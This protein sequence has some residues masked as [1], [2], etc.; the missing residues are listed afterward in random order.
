MGDLQRIWLYLQ[1]TLSTCTNYSVILHPEGK[2]DFG[3]KQEKVLKNFFDKN[4]L[5]T[6]YDYF[7]IFTSHR[8]FEI[9]SYHLPTTSLCSL[10]YV[11]VYLTLIYCVSVSRSTYYLNLYCYCSGNVSESSQG[12]CTIPTLKFSSKNSTCFGFKG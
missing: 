2:H 10:Y 11:L 12:F 4:N 8:E 7:F 3:W 6:L 1:Y 5:L 9:Y